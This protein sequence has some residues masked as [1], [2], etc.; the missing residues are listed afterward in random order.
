VVHRDLHRYCDDQVKHL[1]R[2]V[3]IPQPFVLGTFLARF[4]RWRGRRID[5]LPYDHVPGGACGMWLRLPDSDVIAY[6]NTTPLHG[7]HIILHEVGHMLCGH[8]GGGDVGE[9]LVRALLPDLDPTMVRRVLGRTAYSDAEERQAELI[10][11]LVLKKASDDRPSGRSH[12]SPD[13]VR[14]LDRLR[15]TFEG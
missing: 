11:T 5:L 3:G 10:A 14:E 9:N 8:L 15:S 6:A 2:E 4:A 13:L 1:E 7:E 12:S